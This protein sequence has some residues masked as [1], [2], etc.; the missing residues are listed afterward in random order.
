[1]C[2]SE[3]TRQN[4]APERNE[5]APPEENVKRLITEA[6]SRGEFGHRSVSSL[7]SFSILGASLQFNLSVLGQCGGFH[8]CAMH[9]ICNIVPMPVVTS[10]AF[11]A[12][13][14]CDYTPGGG[15]S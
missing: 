11:I 6:L 3:D 7:D 13:L 10:L 1:M 4:L 15:L 14:L 9:F 5:K 12:L 8:F 2:L